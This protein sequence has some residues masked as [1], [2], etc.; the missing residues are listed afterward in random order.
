[1][2]ACRLDGV[3]CL[4]E[5]MSTQGQGSV[6]DISRR[7][8]LAQS[9]CIALHAWWV[10]DRPEESFYMSCMQLLCTLCDCLAPIT[11]VLPTAWPS[12]CS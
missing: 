12:C 3:L 11:A 5:G 4:Q 7:Q 9:S 2:L 10:L 6:S 1:M 8:T